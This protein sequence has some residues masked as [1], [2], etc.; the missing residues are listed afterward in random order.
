MSRERCYKYPKGPWQKEGS[1]PLPELGACSRTGFGSTGNGNSHL[2]LCR[3]SGGCLP[4]SQKKKGRK[5]KRRESGEQAR[6]RRPRAA[7]P[8]L[9][10]P[11]CCPRPWAAPWWPSLR[12]PRPAGHCPP[13]GTSGAY[14]ASAAIKSG[15]FPWNFLLPRARRRGGLGRPP[16]QVPGGKRPFAAGPVGPEP[17]CWR[18]GPRGGGGARKLGRGGDGRTHRTRLLLPSDWPG[19]AVGAGA[20][21]PGLSGARGA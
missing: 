11:G 13:P 4:G 15:C 21:S 5:R 2:G 3:R 19:G 9:R 7:P 20:A 16:A 10:L 14:P 6:A 17:R 12:T 1:P 18:A 8:P